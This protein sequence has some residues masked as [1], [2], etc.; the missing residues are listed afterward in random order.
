M[1]MN[2]LKDENENILEEK[3]QYKQLISLQRE[4]LMSE[5]KKVNQAAFDFFYFDL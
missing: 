5:E 4:Q 3:N 2:N 1:T